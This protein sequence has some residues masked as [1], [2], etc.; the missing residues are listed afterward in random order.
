M[1]EK[2]ILILIGIVGTI[3]VITDWLVNLRG[4]V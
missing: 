1:D 4:K 3:A 2:V